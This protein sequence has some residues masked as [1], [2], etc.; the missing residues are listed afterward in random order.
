MA[1]FTQRG[2]AVG[3]KSTFGVLV[4]MIGGLMDGV[5]ETSGANSNLPGPVDIIYECIVIFF[6]E[7][8]NHL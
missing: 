8:F 3:E 5:M 1:V 4:K 6:R 2:E 7:I